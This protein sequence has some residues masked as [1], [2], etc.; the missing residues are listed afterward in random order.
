MDFRS[1]L[2][3]PLLGLPL[4]GASCQEGAVHA[5][6]A[7]DVTAR[8][9]APEAA[10]EAAKK[11]DSGAL[12]AEEQD[13]APEPIAAPA[14]EAAPA[15]VLP[16]TLDTVLRLAEEQNT[17]VALARARVAE[18]CAETD[19]AAKRWLPDLYI[20]TG[21]YRHEG[22]I[23][24]ENGNAIY[25]STGALLSG[26]EL[27]SVLDLR[28]QTYRSVVAQ[29]KQW[30]QKGEL[31]KITSETLLDAASTYLDLLT[32]VT[33]QAI[34]RSLETD[35]AGLL[36]QAEKLA[37]NEPAAEVEVERIKAELVGRKNNQ[38]QLKAQADAAS[39][40][41]VYLL[42]LD[43]CTVLLPADKEIVPVELVDIGNCTGDL[44]AR[45]LGQG[46]G[47][48]E[49][50]GLVALVEDAIKKSQGMARF[51]PTFEMRMAEGAFGAG[52]GQ[53]LDYNNRWDL[54]LQMRWN[55]TDFAK[56]KEASRIADAQRNQ[57]HLAYQDLRGKLTAGVHEARESIL[58]GK[59]QI[60]LSKQ[61][62]E[63]ARKARA[64]SKTRLDKLIPGA[65]ASES[66]LSLQSVAMAQL[67][68]LNAVREY[69]KAQ[70]RL[71]ILTGGAGA[72]C[73][74]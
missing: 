74:E 32:A 71:L 8:G 13:G 23:Q 28:E 72:A 38:R 29:R 24:L 46:P 48:R 11:E 45:A 53:V 27:H 69:N 2:K 44:V 31:S 22:G 64:L 58:A 37:A 21:W 65:T 59:D 55:L 19:L 57:A 68:H 40:K 4:L 35:L 39:A 42:G 17:Q 70:L 33:G 36:P 54:G 62:I 14:A 30:Q 1:L 51:L 15:N 66:L 16:I 56:R 34:A 63:H 47:V 9:A 43:P 73:H 49:L 7:P 41:L 60:D 20:G 67:A 5:Q 3:L 52:Q 25:S 12:D 26:V 6:L 61:Q 10:E 50:E 18:A